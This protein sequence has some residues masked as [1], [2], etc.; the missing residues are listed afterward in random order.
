MND[1]NQTN[2][3]NEYDEIDL[4]ELAQVLLAHIKLLILALVLGA[5]AAFAIS[6]FMITPQ[7]TATSTLYIFNKTDSTT[8]LSDLQMGTQLTNDFQVLATSQPVM[9]RVIQE[10]ALNCDYETLSKSVQIENPTSTRLLKIKVTNPDPVLAADISNALAESLRDCVAEIMNVDKP[11]I[12]AEAVPPTR[13]SSPNN[14]R[15]AMLGGA[16]GLVLAAGFIIVRWLLDDT[17][18]S[19]E[20]IQKYLG[21]NTLAEIPIEYDG[22]KKKKN[23]KKKQRKSNTGKAAR[24]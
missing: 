13:K 6:K 5:G 8:S 23:K 3:N 14:S 19:A 12:A 24:A 16:L 18:K 9:D 20:D 1:M 21:L 17:V 10:L 15:N 4:L 7:Y 2:N 22:Q 11:S